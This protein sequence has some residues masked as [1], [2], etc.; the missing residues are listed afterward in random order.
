[1][2]ASA[3][4]VNS[5]DITT[6]IHKDGS[7]SIIEI[8]D[9]DVDGVAETEWY[10]AKHNLDDMDIIDLNV[11]ENIGDGAV[12]FETLAAWDEKAARDAKAQRC[13]LL[14]A[15]GGYEICWGIGE[16]GHHIYTLGYTITNMVK[17]YQGGDAM[18]FNFLS[19]V[20]GGLDKLVISLGAD[21]FAF[22]N[23]ATRIWA[24]GYSATVKYADGGVIVTSNGRFTQNDRAALLLA[25]DQ[26]LLS[27]ADIRA[28]KL[29]EIIGLVA[30]DGNSGAG[31][32]Y[33]DL[34]NL[35]YNK[36]VFTVFNVAL[37]FGLVILPLALTRKKRKQLKA[38]RKAPYCRELPFNGDIGATYAR[39]CDMNKTNSFSVVGCFLLKWLHSG[40]AEI[41]ANTNY[42][43]PTIKLRAAGPELSAR[44]A[45]LYG[46]FTAAAGPDM[47]LRDKDFKNWSYKNL[48]EIKKW[49]QEYRAFYK[50]ELV[51]I[52][53]YETVPYKRRFGMPKGTAYNETPLAQDLTL[54]AFGFK[55]YLEDFMGVGEKDARNSGLA[56]AG[57]SDWPFQSVNESEAREAWDQY[58]LFAQL[59]GI[60][61]FLAERFKNQRT[62][63]DYQESLRCIG[64]SLYIASILAVCNSFSKPLQ[65]FGGGLAGGS[66]VGFS[67]G[68]GAGGR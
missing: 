10:V 34:Q 65:A 8:W 5:V 2:P 46:M 63:G 39:L 57:P 50:S 68:G 61:D 55:R 58:L 54:R 42:G 49:L 36:F 18:R 3:D 48:R 62:G 66:A 15:K 26:G 17:G 23:P 27:P 45:S 19:D 33:N 11:Q 51:R 21:D 44:E 13:G 16:P 1:M 37:A 35:F 22:V 41:V 28:Q 64:G 43:E 67:G 40:Q 29:D 9:I 31:N 12:A 52:G 32:N 53:V 24:T 20:S 30:N 60:T 14:K 56:D 6:L 25:F 4:S 38:L 47:I 59:F 7:A